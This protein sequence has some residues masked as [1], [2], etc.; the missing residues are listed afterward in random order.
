MTIALLWFWLGT[1]T[2]WPGREAPDAADWG[3]RRAGD[4]R[5]AVEALALARLAH[6]PGTWGRPLHTWP[7]PG[8]VRSG[9][10]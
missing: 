3:R 2:V 4:W 6:V 5:R 8:P 9:L 1:S 7:W 10:W